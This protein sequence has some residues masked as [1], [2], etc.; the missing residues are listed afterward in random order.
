MKK[1]FPIILLS[2]SLLLL[3]SCNLIPGKKGGDGSTSDITDSTSASTSTSE[4]SES[5]SSTSQDV[6]DHCEI[7]TKGDGLPGANAW[8]VAQNEEHKQ[9]FL[10]CL[11]QSAGIDIVKDYNDINKIFIQNHE[12][13]TDKQYSHLTIGA[14]KSSGYGGKLYLRMNKQIKKVAVTFS[15]FYKTTTTNIETDAKLII[16]EKETF[17]PDFLDT[18]PQPTKRVEY[19]YEEP[20]DI[21]KFSNDPTVGGQRVYIDLIELYY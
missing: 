7:V 20:T 19:V 3:S 10:D 8:D 12:G 2:S 17:Y 5:S 6:S 21:V 9:Q 11:N 13:G 14:G 18:N 1:S 16:D 15:A 4:S